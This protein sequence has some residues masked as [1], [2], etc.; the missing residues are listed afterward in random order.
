[1]AKRF[2]KINFGERISEELGLPKQVLAG[3]NHI[4]LLGNR[5]AVV[6][7]CEGILEYSDSRIK[8][9]MGKNDVLFS[10]SDLCIKEYGTAHATITGEIMTVE[11]S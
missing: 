6:N 5:E 2:E 8:I 4:E 1:M 9:N 10:G 3:Y 7:S 11:F